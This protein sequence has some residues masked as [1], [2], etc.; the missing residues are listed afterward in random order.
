MVQPL[1]NRGEDTGIATEFT[2]NLKP[3]TAF[4]F[5]HAVND[6][7]RLQNKEDFFN[8]TIK[9]KFVPFRFGSNA[10]HGITFNGEKL[11][12]N[13]FY[14]KVTFY[15]K[16]ANTG[17]LKFYANNTHGGVYGDMVYFPEKEPALAE[18]DNFTFSEDQK[19]LTYIQP[20]GGELQ[21][22]TKDDDYLKL[23]PNTTKI[24]GDENTKFLYYYNGEPLQENNDNY[25]VKEWTTGEVVVKT[26]RLENYS[27]TV[28]VKEQYRGT[29]AY[30]K[31]QFYWDGEK[32]F[33]GEW[34]GADPTDRQSVF[35]RFG[36]DWLVGDPVDAYDID[37][38]LCSMDAKGVYH[39]NK[40]VKS[41]KNVKAGSISDPVE[42]HL[43]GDVFPQDVWDKAVAAGKLNMVDEN[44]QQL[45]EMERCNI[46]LHL[47]VYKAGTREEMFTNLGD[48]ER[49]I[50]MTQTFSSSF[51]NT[52]DYLGILFP[53]AFTFKCAYLMQGQ[54]RLS[55]NV[56]VG[57]W[58]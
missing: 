38:Y 54:W 16:L 20:L 2:L 46:Y 37:F 53:P 58:E 34:T 50:D 15:K 35:F 57:S 12:L 26:Y 17:T 56:Q 32:V 45:P 14:G 23:R 36:A 44:Y 51:V 30:D 7:P 13:T 47:T 9:C 21:W 3:D 6:Q 1:N 49:Y 55:S 43:K 29:L 52:E 18:I 8:V 4:T 10:N 5:V 11:D 42:I 33:T 25:A 27:D 48:S 28:D 40:L 22:F 19:R 24:T 41:L 31:L 39:Q